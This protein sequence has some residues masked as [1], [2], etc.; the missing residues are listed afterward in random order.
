[1]R[2]LV[3]LGGTLLEDQ[4]ARN[5][6][7]AQLSEVSRHH[8]LTVVHGGGKQVTKFLEERGVESR[9]VSG[10]RVS[11]EAVIDAVTKVI[12]GGLNKQLVSALVA[13]G[14]SA[15]GLSGVDGPLTTATQLNPDLGFVGKP[16]RTN[17]VLLSLLVSANYVPVVACIAG[18]H[19]GHIYNVNADQ[20]AVSCA[21][22]WRA[23]KLF[24]LTDVPGVKDAT[25]AVAPHLTIPQ[26]RGLITSGIAHGGMQAKLEAA[27]AAIEGGLNEVWIASGRVPDICLR[28]L[29]SDSVGTR[30][31]A[32]EV[33]A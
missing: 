25:G 26:S 24:F 22:G 27:E 8:E 17:G 19:E 10:L 23:H 3:K 29:R 5:A 1:V 6:I 32:G 15:V 4:P 31:T 30:V 2:I 12:A 21:V 28:L 11:D 13:A 16:G 33:L 7:A 14:V 18:D 9:F 20:M